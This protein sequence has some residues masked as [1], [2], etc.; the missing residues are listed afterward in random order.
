ML[1]RLPAPT[2]QV[3]LDGHPVSVI[4]KS[5]EGGVAY[6]V[7]VVAGEHVIELKNI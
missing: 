2:E 5:V 1:V 7:A 4:C 6:L 3:T